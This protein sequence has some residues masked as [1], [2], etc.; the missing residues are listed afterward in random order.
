Q[1]GLRA[2]GGPGRDPQRDPLRLAELEQHLVLAGDA[3]AAEGVER[4][5]DRVALRAVQIADAGR[6]LGQRLDQRPDRVGVAGRLQDRRDAVA[7]A[8]DERAVA[9]DESARVL[10]PLDG[11]VRALPGLP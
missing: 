1:P 2:D 3:G 11:G 7:G 4:R 5:V 9:A 10:L 8:V 6:A